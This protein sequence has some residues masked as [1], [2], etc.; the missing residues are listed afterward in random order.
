MKFPTNMT[1]EK[2]LSGF[3]RAAF[4]GCVITLAILAWMPAKAITRTILGGHVEHFIAYLG[5]AVLMGLANRKRPLLAVQCILLIM[6]AA[7]LEA[8]QVY[9]PDRHPSF[10]DLAF[11]SAGVV[12]GGLFL[13]MG[14]DRML[15]WL[16]ID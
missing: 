6:Y 12:V 9:S 8:G 2:L 16:R 13:R 4:I 11:S 1:T 5:T 10:E 3:L 15:S 14:R 7:F